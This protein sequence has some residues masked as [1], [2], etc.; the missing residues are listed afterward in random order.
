[1]PLLKHHRSKVEVGKDIA[2]AGGKHFAFF[3]LRAEAGHGGI[4]TQAEA[5][6][7]ARDI[8]GVTSGR[9]AERH[10]GLAETEAQREGTGRVAENQAR[11]TKER[12]IEGFHI[13]GIFGS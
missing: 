12:L 1:M 5:G 8:L 13:V 9:T 11:M 3:Q 2:Q 7:E 4:C 6:R 10:A